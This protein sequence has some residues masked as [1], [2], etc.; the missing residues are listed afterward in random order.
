[1]IFAGPRR[2]PRH[3]GEAPGKSP[4][5]ADTVAGH[6]VGKEVSK[7]HPLVSPDRLYRSPLWELKDHLEVPIDQSSIL[8]SSYRTCCGQQDFFCY[9]WPLQVC[10][11][12]H[13]VCNGVDYFTDWVLTN[14]LM[15]FGR[16][17]AK[18]ETF[19]KWLRVPLNFRVFIQFDGQVSRASGA[20]PYFS[21]TASCAASKPSQKSYFGESV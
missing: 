12:F 17:C 20:R 15:K 9:C 14:I 8:R 11:M 2:A 3:P 6:R 5:P 1:M 10:N 4:A 18:V 21:S 19:N 13:N 16:C 7:W